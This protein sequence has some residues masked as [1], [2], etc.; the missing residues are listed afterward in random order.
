MRRIPDQWLKTVLMTMYKQPTTT[1]GEILRSTGFNPVRQELD[2]HVRD[3]MGSYELAVSNL[4]VEY[5]L[6]GSSSKA[7]YSVLSNTQLLR[8]FYGLDLSK[9][10]LRKHNRPVSLT[11]Y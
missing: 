6:K 8:R 2:R 10:P 5:G 11:N 7:F 4:G 3:W 9:G 1:R